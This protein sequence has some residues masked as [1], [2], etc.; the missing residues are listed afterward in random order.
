MKYV[1]AVSLVL[2]TACSSTQVRHID[3]DVDSVKGNTSSGV[4]ALKDGHAIIQKETMADDELRVQQWRNDR[5]EEKL[6]AD[7]Y[8]L[9]QCRIDIAD[10][11]LG[12]K[13]ELEP[14]HEIDNMKQVSELKESFGLDKDENL[15]FVTRE[16]FLKRVA[17]E[18]KYSE[19]L[20]S[21]TKA[22]GD[23]LE[24]CEMKLRVARVKAGLPANRDGSLS[25]DH[26]FA[27]K[28]SLLSK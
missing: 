21:M 27:S 8:D 10:T 26:E 20:A 13:G 17:I 2:M 5:A 25:L 4:L 11:R 22:V 6:S 24:K 19:S 14:L 28:S 12:G 3:T 16:D 23:S 18:R 15:K 7:W 1:C 9:K